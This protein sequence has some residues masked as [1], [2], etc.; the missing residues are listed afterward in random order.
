MSDNK[1]E[2]NM[3]HYLQD[4]LDYLYDQDKSEQTIRAYLADLSAFSRWIEERTED[5]FSPHIITPLDIVN[6]RRHLQ[7]N[8]KSPATICLELIPNSCNF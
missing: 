5:P 2:G 8:K 4:F 6:Y 7:D 3:N 1:M